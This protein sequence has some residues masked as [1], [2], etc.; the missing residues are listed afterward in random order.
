MRCWRLLRTDFSAEPLS[1][2]GARLFGGRWNR[3]GT[4]SVYAS[5]HLSLAALELFVRLQMGDSGEVFVSV[6]IEIPESVRVA[7]IEA[8]A[9]PKDWREMPAGRSTQEIGQDW[10]TKG[11][12]AVLMV[13]SVIVPL[14]YNLVLNPHHGDF[15]KLRVGA[16]QSFSYD[17]RMWK[18]S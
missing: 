18:T 1:G 5:E 4:P 2:Q 11:E 10:I 7:R 15:R 12:T 8:G 14:E 16:I 9:L 6:P 3:R 13:P 17:P